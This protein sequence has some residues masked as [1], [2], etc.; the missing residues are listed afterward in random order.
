MKKIKLIINFLIISFFLLL[1]NNSY[2]ID[3]E[4]NKIYKY[5]IQINKILNKASNDKINNIKNKI[6][7]I[8]HNKLWKS[9]YII[10]SNDNKKYI[11]IKLWWDFYSNIK[12]VKIIN[13]KNNIDNYFKKYPLHYWFN[14]NLEKTKDFILNIE[15]NKNKLLCN[16]DKL[17]LNWLLYDILILKTNI[18]IKLDLN[19]VLSCYLKNNLDKYIY[20]TELDTIY[21]WYRKTNIELW[22]NTIKWIYNYWDYINLKNLNKNIDKY[23]Y[24]SILIWTWDKNSFK[25]TSQ[26]S[27]WWWLCWVATAVYQNL[28][29]IPWF[30]IEKVYNHSSYFTSYYWPIFWFDSTVYFSDSWKTAYKNLIVKNEFWS[31][32]LNNF[33]EVEKWKYWKDYI[34]WVKLY[35]LW[36]QFNN[37]YKVKQISHYKKW[38]SDCYKIWFYLNDKLIYTRISCYKK[39]Y[40]PKEI[41]KSK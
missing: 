39:Y 3:L 24:W 26:K 25:I 22:F 7:N 8:I 31:V 40:K 19:K 2:W 41:K 6:L 34:Y 21:H 11:R 36:Y 33:W 28:A 35:S 29:Q 4:M 14:W 5:N 1:I 37:K 18:Y 20:K 27:K 12:W 17:Y 38:E 15:K 10:I 16:Y 9:N 23:V 30:K 13:I 32:Y